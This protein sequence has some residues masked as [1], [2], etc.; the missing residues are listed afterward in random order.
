MSQ[1]QPPTGRREQNSGVYT[2]LFRPPSLHH[3]VHRHRRPLHVQCLPLRKQAHA[4]DVV[5]GPLTEG[6]TVPLRQGGADCHHGR[7]RWWKQL[8]LRPP[9]PV[10]SSSSFLA[11][12]RNQCPPN[13]VLPHVLSC[14]RQCWCRKPLTDRGWGI[15]RCCL[16]TG[17]TGKT[18]L[19]SSPG[20]QAVLPVVRPLWWGATRPPLEGVHLRPPRLLC[21]WGKEGRN[22]GSVG[23]RLGM[24]P[25]GFAHT[26]R[27]EQNT[28]VCPPVAPVKTNCSTKV[29]ALMLW[30]PCQIARALPRTRAQCG[31]SEYVYKEEPS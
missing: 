29:D 26:G 3:H 31:S 24:H 12:R 16:T 25:H 14:C 19:G 7:R 22:I 8:L 23:V 9:L 27:P 30:S 21:L 5:L 28:H 1:S 2:P 13:T 18:S 15:R 6:R 17:G 4:L 10:L 20:W 11:L